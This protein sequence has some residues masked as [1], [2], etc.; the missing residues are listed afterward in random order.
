MTL[1]WQ[2]LF[3][4]SHTP[5][6][7]LLNS[8]PYEIVQLG[9]LFPHTAALVIPAHSQAERLELPLWVSSQAADF[10]QTKSSFLK[11]KSSSLVSINYQLSPD[12]VILGSQ[13]Q[14]STQGQLHRGLAPG[15]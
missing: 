7:T 1:N 5:S 9:F 6:I 10:T 11:T 12:S 14:H 8:F 2:A 4:D 3:R 13:L 15:E